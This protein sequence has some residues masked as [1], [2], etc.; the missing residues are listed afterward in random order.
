MLE[1]HNQMLDLKKRKGGLT[2]RS[3]LTLWHWIL[4]SIKLRH[5]D[6]ALMVA[7]QH[8]METIKFWPKVQ[9]FYYFLNLR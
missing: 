1:K 4:E 7:Y 5:S 2:I 6:L 9:G 8:V 3:I